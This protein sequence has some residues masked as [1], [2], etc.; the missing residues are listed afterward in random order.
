MDDD[1]DRVLVAL[2]RAD[3]TTES[4]E[5]DWVIEPAARTA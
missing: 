3:G 5:A 4:V 1:G 2:K